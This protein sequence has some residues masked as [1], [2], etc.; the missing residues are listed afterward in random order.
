MIVLGHEFGYVERRD[1]GDTAMKKKRHRVPGMNAGAEFETDGCM[2]STPAFEFFAGAEADL[3]RAR[4]MGEAE[5]GALMMIGT[6]D[7]P[8]NPPCEGPVVIHEDGAI[9]C[10]GGCPGIRFAYHG[11][12]STRACDTIEGDLHGQCDR[13][14][15]HAA[16]NR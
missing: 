16:A 8:A 7:D 14:K 10:L 13:C 11:P 2:S 1:Y 15:R 9:E 3:A 6:G 5:F 12:G 4:G